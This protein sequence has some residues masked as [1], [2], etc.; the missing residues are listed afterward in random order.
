MTIK[1]R[2]ILKWIGI[3]LLSPIL[4]FVLLVILLYIPPIQNWVA[5]RVCSYASEQTGMQISVGHVSLKFPLDLSISDFRMLKANDSIPGLTDT[6]A[7][8][9]E[10]VVDVQLWPL[11]KSKVEI[12]G[13]DLYR[14]RLNTNGFIASTRV[15]GELQHL[16]LESH[17]INLKDNTVRVNHAALTDARFDVSLSDTVPPDTTE[18]ET[19]WRLL[20]DDVQ[21]TRTALTLHTPRDES[22][23]RADL[24]ELQAKGGYVDLAASDYR[25]QHFELKDGTIGY[26]NNLVPEPRQ[27]KGAAAATDRPLDTD[28]LLLTDVN[29]GLDSLV[30]KETPVL[31]HGRPVRDAEGNKVTTSRIDAQLRHCSLHE[32]SG[33]QI[34]DLSGHVTLAD[35]VL[36]LPTLHM[37]TPHSRLDANVQVDFNNL[38]ASLREGLYADIDGSIGRADIMR[39]A[40]SALPRQVA[41]RWPAAPLTI[42]GLVRGNMQRMEFSH[43]SVNLPGTLRM[44]T[45]GYAENIS[46]GGPLRADL[47]LHATT[48]NTA[49]LTDAYLDPRTTGVNIPGGITLDGHVKMNGENY[50][51]N[52]SIGQ[53]GGTA[54]VKGFFDSR[55]MRYDA[56]VSAQHFPLH[57]FLPGQGLSAFSGNVSVRG[58]GTDIMSPHTHITADADIRQLSYNGQSLAGTRLHATVRGGHINANIASRHP[59]LQ[60]DINLTATTRGGT[61]GALIDADLSRVDLQALGI[62]DRQLVTAGHLHADVKTDLKSHYQVDGTVRN[63]AITQRRGVYH[64]ADIDLHLLSRR[65]T[66]YAQVATGDMQLRLNADSGHEQLLA[67]LQKV[68]KA[69]TTQ[70]QQ[71]NLK[72]E[73]LYAML[74]DMHI[75]LEAGHNN[76]LAHILRDKEIAFSQAAIHLSTAPHTG[77]NGSIALD[78]VATADMLID[79]ARLN[80]STHDNT[81][82]FDG[83]VRNNAQ[84]PYYTFNLLFDGQQQ[85]RGIALNTKLYDSKERLAV[86]LGAATEM[87]DNGMQLVMTDLNPVLAYKQ[88]SVNADNRIFLASDKRLSAQ[89]MLRA[90]DNTSIQIY[91]NDDNTEALQD[92]TVSVQ[93]IDLKALTE[94]LP[95]LPQLG[96]ILNGD[97][98]IIQTENQFSVSTAME[99]ADMELEGCRLGNIGADLVYI[100]KSD[101]SHFVDG[102]LSQDGSE[103]CTLNGSYLPDG[104]GG[105]NATLGM[106][107][108]PLAMVNGFLGDGFIALRGYA[109]GDISVRGPLSQLDIDGQL[110]TDSAY[111]DLP[112][113]GIA[114]RFDD[115]PLH[116][117]HSTLKFDNFRLYGY[118]NEPL[119]LNGALDFRRFDSMTLSLR[120]MARNFQLI[121][122]KET[123]QAEAYGKAFINFF[124]MV[125]GPVSQLTMRGRAD[126][127]GA[128]DMTYVLKDSPLTTDNRLQELVTFVDFSDTTAVQTKKAELSGI[129][130]DL[131]LHIDEAAHIKCDLNADHSNYIDLIGGGDLRLQT[132]AAEGFR[133]TGKYTLANGEMKYSLPVIPL[134]TFHIKDGSYIEFSGDPENPT[135]H[136]TAVEKTSAAV[137]DGGGASRTVDFECGVV[138]TQ[139]LQNM[140]LEFVIEAPEDMTVTNELNTLSKEERG[141]IAVTMLTTGMYLGDGGGSGN[142]NMNNALGAFLQSEI[143]NIT[144]KALRTLDLQFG[145]DNTTDASGALHTDYSFKF[146]KRFWNNRLK[147]SI[148]GKVSTGAEV[149]NQDNSFLD[150]VTFE[151]RL[152]P[153]SNKYVNLFYDRNSYDWIEGNVGKY[154]AGFLWKRKVQHFRDIFRFKSDRPTLPLRPLRRDSTATL[155]QLRRDSTRTT[156]TTPQP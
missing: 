120:M 143:N 21:L 142:L 145:V 116:F 48:G 91:T 76:I 83:Q 8:V 16:H 27:T 71:R 97:Y 23:I 72:Q 127:L 24:G 150:N 136:I 1:P 36:K 19:K 104:E 15:K 14:T 84:N 75:D 90:D 3:A 74:P 51:G 52:V 63:L 134:K 106:Q 89:L 123:P 126:I 118:N 64:A 69:F 138:V 53:D 33:L 100:P 114:L 88:F 99:I 95:F 80:L 6:I 130:M 30:Y 101:G 39:F 156:T 67:R 18:S 129:D 56:T 28:H 151:Y 140:G 17:N 92:L 105:L 22:T 111:V 11:L 146:A 70:L 121:N 107:R 86:K 139:T 31:R 59:L 81:L 137:S 119:T 55:A 66:L 133:L 128:T 132:T 35:G 125:S 37:Q 155:P 49:W 12:D 144:G 20:I 45:S 43:L 26:D 135:L 152:S 54:R 47:T 85:E 154:G 131:T 87:H 115:R 7:D 5:Q 10:L 29:I 38:G 65:D 79:V 141:K 82:N 60:G 9:G 41:A 25:L 108:F 73:E 113:Y 96:G 42:K 94:P 147:I 13:F 46:G 68:G 40:G 102:I 58:N 78:S 50:S 77:I 117:H 2:K 44:Q 62:T 112:N 148:G 153:T 98:H 93:Q 61:M 110:L 57:H 122:A 124:G 4:L 103:V 109:N 32:Q 149:Y 34:D